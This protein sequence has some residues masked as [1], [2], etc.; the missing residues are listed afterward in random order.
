MGREKRKERSREE[1]E[2]GERE[3]QTGRGKGRWVGQPAPRQLEMA[4][5]P[6][7]SFYSWGNR[8]L[9]RQD[10][11]GESLCLARDW[12]QSRRAAA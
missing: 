1:E 6:F 9:E 12:L 4:P 10:V 5:F 11:R 2:E 3:R 8:G 7:V